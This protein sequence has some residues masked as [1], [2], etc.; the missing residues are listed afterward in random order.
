MLETIILSFCSLVHILAAAHQRKSKLCFVP[1]CR[2]FR[3]FRRKKTR[4]YLALS[5]AC[6]PVNRQ[7]NE[8][9]QQCQCLIFCRIFDRNCLSLNVRGLNKSIKRRTVDGYTNKVIM[10]SF[11]KNHTALK[12]LLLSKKTNGVAK[13]FLV[14]AQTT[15]KVS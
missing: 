3:K 6:V 8:Q 5:L 14:T 4:V 11:C 15:V 7:Q 1:I 12:I 13:L 9:R 2:E 10:S